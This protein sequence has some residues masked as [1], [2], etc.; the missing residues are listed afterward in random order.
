M[1][2][3]VIQSRGAPP[4]AN[5]CFRYSRRDRPKLQDSAVLLRRAMLIRFSTTA[6]SYSATASFPVEQRRIPES[7]FLD[8]V[9]V[10][11]LGLIGHAGAARRVNER[12]RRNV[13]GD[14]SLN[15]R[16]TSGRSVL[17]KSW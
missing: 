16:S 7:F 4:E 1:V 13:F 9:P 15:Y 14:P 12:R 3:S 17:E 10:P 2:G 11:R 8:T 6:P 5:C